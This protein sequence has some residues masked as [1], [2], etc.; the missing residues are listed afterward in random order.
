MNTTVIIPDLLCTG[1]GVSVRA[2]CTCAMPYLPKK[3]FAATKA[4]E[5]NP[6]K[7]NRAI[8]EEI[9]VNKDTVRAA[10]NAVTGE[11]NSP[12]EK[13]VGLDGKARR[14]PKPRR[15]IPSETRRAAAKAV[16][17][18]GKRHDDVAAEFG[19]ATGT[20]SAVVQ[21]ELARREN[22]TNEAAVRQ[23]LTAEFEARYG[24]EI[25]DARAIKKAYKAKWTR[26]QY[27]LVLRCL[28]PDNSATAEQRARAFNLV[29][30]GAVWLCGGG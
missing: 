23:K 4:V 14:M 29:R 9:G 1:C 20:V 10:R 3:L 13:R 8:A 22:P 2:S 12:V 15:K 6:E 17:D 21:E 7:S 16:I 19:I 5:E 11:K 24:K 27:I 28:H 30:Q 18:G 25:D 26:D